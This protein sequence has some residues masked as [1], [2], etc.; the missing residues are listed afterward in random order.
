MFLAYQINTY[1]S[2][3]E[4][5]PELWEQAGDALNVTMSYDY[6]HLL[7][8]LHKNEVRFHYAAIVQNDL[9]KGLICFQTIKFKGA[10]LNN[11]LRAGER[12]NIF[13]RFLIATIGKILNLMSWDVLLS[14]NIFFTGEKG[15]HFSPSVNDEDAVK[16]IQKSYE[17]VCAR[18]PGKVTAYMLNNV[19]DDDKPYMHAFLKEFKYASY[20]VDPDMFMNVNG[21]W[22]SFEAYTASFSSK[23]RTRMK[24]VL[25]QSEVVELRK[26]TLEELEQQNDLIFGLYMRTASK[27][28]FNLGYLSPEYFTSMKRQYG[29]DF[30]VLAYYVGTEMVGFM[31]ILI[32]DEDLDINYMGLNY[33]VNRQY[34]LYNR[35]LFDLVR[36][37]IEVGAN[38]M[39]LGRTATEIKS[40]VGAK[41]REMHIYLSS[42]TS[43]KARGMRFFEPYFGSPKYTV[44]SPFKAA[45]N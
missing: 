41:P 37:S 36:Y 24:K 28:A 22:S 33:D 8:K 21:N 38:C 45:I 32:L 27:A 29:D 2:I 12:S 17:D 35:M 7:E 25:R 10:Y 40:T 18:H 14:G 23:Y 19:Y 1:R 26:L 5:N 30:Q 44:R 15:I 16:L 3:E 20:P 9:F 6:L 43:W 4:M 34:R 42:P 11:F 31:S 39:H 13:V